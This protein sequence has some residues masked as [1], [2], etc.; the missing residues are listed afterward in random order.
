MP[1]PRPLSI[2][3]ERG[4]PLR[5]MDPR[6]EKEA[7]RTSI[8]ERLKRLSPEDRARES[9]SLCKRLLAALPETPGTICVFYPMVGS[10][11]DI[12]E[13][14]PALRERGWA[15]FFPR[16]EGSAFA[17]RRA[18]SDDALV[19]GRY[20]LKEPSKDEEALAI[21]DVAIAILPGLAFD[22]AGG[23][24]GRG[25]GGYDRW[26]RDLRKRNPSAKVWGV[27]LECQM[28]PV[29]PKEP[30]DETVDLVVTP[31]GVI[32]PSAP[33]TFPR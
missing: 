23:R 24:I 19:P 20:G 16:F 6:S 30:H 22:P 10:E 29:V 3:T 8:K 27:A 11:A 26:L 1:H 28:V 21:E 14:F 2:A 4:A 17:F 18:D 31:R 7:L 15:V 9:R 25:N 5:T 32:D 13:L 33:G 12:R